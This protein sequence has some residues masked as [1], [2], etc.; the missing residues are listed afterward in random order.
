MHACIRESGLQFEPAIKIIDRQL[1][2]HVLKCFLIHEVHIGNNRGD[3]P[4]IE[5]PRGVDMRGHTCA[6]QLFNRSGV[7]ANRSNLR[8]A[9]GKQ[10]MKIVDMFI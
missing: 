7:R 10:I 9:I 8:Q 5:H 6:I 1:K 4:A 3:Q 2:T